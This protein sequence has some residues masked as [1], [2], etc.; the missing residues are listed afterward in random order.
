MKQYSGNNRQ[1]SA[2]N[3]SLV[4]QRFLKPP[5]FKQNRTSIIEQGPMEKSFLSYRPS[6]LPPVPEK[7]SLIDNIN[8][9]TANDEN[10]S[11]QSGV[12]W[13]DEQL[14]GENDY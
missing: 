3:I 6:S 8:S 12:I 9:I 13:K 14:D 4:S 11:K 1:I 10:D 5:T 7:T 2:K